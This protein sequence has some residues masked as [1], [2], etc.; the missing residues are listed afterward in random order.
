MADISL[1]YGRTKVTFD[2][3]K[4]LGK[5]EILKSPEYSSGSPLNIIKYALE[6]PY[7]DKTIQEIFTPA[8][9]VC[10]VVSDFT[11]YYQRM[12]LFLP[13]IIEELN[14]A[15]I[16]DSQIT[17]VCAL[18]AHAPQTEE[19][20]EQILGVLKDRFLL[21]EHN[22]HNEDELVHLGMSKNGTPIELSRYVVEADKVI[23]TGAIIYHDMAGFSGGRKALLPG[24]A[25]YS[26]ISANHLQVFA[27]EVGTGLNPNCYLGNIEGNP[28]HEDMME[29][30]EIIKPSF[31]FNVILDGNNE[32]YQA[33]A[34]EHDPA[35]AAG[36]KYCEEACAVRIEEK[37]DV[38]IA[39]CGGYPKDINLYQASKGYATGIE[40]VKNGGTIILVAACEDGMGNEESVSIITDYSEQ[41]EREKYMR[42]E[43]KPEA[44]SGYY[45]CEA[46]R[47]YDLVL[48]SK[49]M[50]PADLEGSGVTLFRT[51]DEALANIE[52]IKNKK[53]YIIPYSM[54]VVPV[55]K[56]K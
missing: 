54:S 18:G 22:C 44:Y 31:I 34:G 48:V 43:F 9:N 36:I 33:V 55:L 37:A 8:D 4:Y 19:E 32:Y 47:H 27:D 49:Y 25:S 45:I 17:L 14:D 53:T 56:S 12:D 46:A 15:G 5:Y 3:E 20:K 29:A 24:L 10:I 16:A 52:D 30:L 21:H 26:S 13:L 23:L 51:I 38:V 28:M 11:R 39:A 6:H 1:K 50:E 7:G 40:A 2:P 42:T 41:I 35:F